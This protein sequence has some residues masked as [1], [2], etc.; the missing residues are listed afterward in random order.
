MRVNGCAPCPYCE[1]QGA[2]VC[3]CGELFCVG[4]LTQNSV[5]CPGCGVVL[6]RNHMGPATSVDIRQ[7]H[8]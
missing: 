1:N 4:E 6:H 5:E 7:S 2:G 8:G 3:D